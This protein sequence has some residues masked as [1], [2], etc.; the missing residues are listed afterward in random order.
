LL[1]ITQTLDDDF[2]NLISV[3]LFA[4]RN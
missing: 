2:D 3:I 1:Q 4:Q